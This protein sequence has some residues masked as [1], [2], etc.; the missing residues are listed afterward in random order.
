M[1]RAHPTKLFDRPTTCPGETQMSKGEDKKKEAKK[2][3]L[4]NMKEKRAEKKA[5]KTGRSG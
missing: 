1:D 5:K 2:Q 4:K 3:P